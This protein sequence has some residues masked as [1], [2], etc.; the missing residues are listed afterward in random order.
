MQNFL[1]DLITRDLLSKKFCLKP[2]S[3]KNVWP[4]TI[5]CILTKKKIHFTV[6][7]LHFISNVLEYI[8]QFLSATC[9]LKI[10]KKNKAF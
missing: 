7:Q 10:T 9:Y 2:I 8:E 5:H 6:V 4:F 3:N 1:A